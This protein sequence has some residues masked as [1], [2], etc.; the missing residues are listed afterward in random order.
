ML[1]Q[2]R[3]NCV[4]IDTG[5]FSDE[6]HVTPTPLLMTAKNKTWFRWI[7]GTWLIFWIL[8]LFDMHAPLWKAL[9]CCLAVIYVGAFWLVSRG[10]IDTETGLQR[11]SNVLLGLLAVQIAV[12][13]FI[14]F[15]AAGT[16]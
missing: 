6:G 16:R 8:G 3:T 11:V 4:N 12:M 14:A 15:R 5:P 7:A 10:D 9:W 2:Q 13:F 1:R